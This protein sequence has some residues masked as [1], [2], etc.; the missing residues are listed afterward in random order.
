MVSR[1]I[2][3][4]GKMSDLNTVLSVLKAAYAIS[5]RSK[6]RERTHTLE[7]MEEIA[8]TVK[9]FLRSLCEMKV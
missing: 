4:Q 1:V 5:E 2:I 9:L 6:V 3:E 7:E 8:T